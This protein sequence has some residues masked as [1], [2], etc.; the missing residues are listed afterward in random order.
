MK[1]NTKFLM[2]FIIL[3][4]FVGQL[5]VFAQEEEVP[6]KKTKEAKKSLWQLLQAGGAVGWLIVLCSFVGVALII[7]HFVNIKR[8]KLCPPEIVGELEVLMEEKQ[9]EDA[10]TICE[11]NSAFFPFVMASALAKAE[12]GV[13]A[14]KKAASDAGEEAAFKLFQKIG[15]LNLL[16]QVAPMLGLLGTVTGMIGAFQIIA[17]TANPTPA[18]LA[19]GVYEALVTTCEGLIVAIPVLCFYFFF[20]NRVTALVLELSMLAN[21]LLETK[22]KEEPQKTE[23]KPPVSAPVQQKPQQP[24]R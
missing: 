5:C 6:A 19:T 21:E 23:A 18:Q 14:M 13:E 8:E 3:F 10:L 17:A 4:F 16:G 15:W 7:E 1:I 11:A 24:K 20:K 22:I 2:L 9:Y 12:D